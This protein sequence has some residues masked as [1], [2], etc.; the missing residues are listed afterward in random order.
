M[1]LHTSWWEKSLGKITWA[2]AKLQTVFVHSD[3]CFRKQEG[4]LGA[5]LCPTHF[6]C[7]YQVGI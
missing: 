5:I 7:W 2:Q 4:I 1:I 6:F 3:P